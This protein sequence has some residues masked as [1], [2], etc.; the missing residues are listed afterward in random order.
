M[1][2]NTYNIN[3]AGLDDGTID[4]YTLI[5]EPV[6]ADTETLN[7]KIQS[8]YSEAQANR[9]HRN[10]NKRREFQTLLELLPRARKAL[11]EPEKRAR[12]NAYLA[13]ARSGSAEVEFET[14]MG[15]L[16]GTNETMEEKTGLLGTQDSSQPRA[17]VIKAPTEAPSSAAAKAKKPVA[18]SGGVK[19]GA[20][21]GS[22]GGFLIGAFIGN[23]M[24]GGLVPAILVGIIMAAIIFVVLNRKPRPGIR[25]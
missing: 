10:L 15:D 16:L 8:L 17:R 14:F 25:N 4:F 24:L 1:A 20:L 13:S 3:D 7:A 9:D 19:T 5:Q 12:Y 23:S 11:S 6:D 2:D 18:A 21:V 22:I